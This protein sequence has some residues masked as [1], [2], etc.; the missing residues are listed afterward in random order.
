MTVAPVLLIEDTPSLQMVYRSVLRADGHSV[1]CEGTAAGGLRAFRQLRPRV[2]LLDLMLPDRDGLDLIQDFLC[3]ESET[4]VIVI[5][6]D[7][8]INKAV[9]AMRAGAYEFLV[10]PFDDQRLLGAVRSALDATRP[11][12]TGSTTPSTGGLIGSSPAMQAVYDIVGSVARSMATVFIT[13]ECGT[14][15]ELC[16]QAVHESSN[17]SAGPFVS[18]NCGAIAAEHL[19]SELFGHLKG[20]FAGALSDKQGAAAAADGGTLFLDEICEMDLAMQTKLLRFLQT[21]SIQPVGA[22]RSRKVDV[23]IVCATNNDPL[24]AV[25]RGRFRQDLYYRLHVVPIHMPSLRERGADVVEIA[26]TM[27]R[28][29]AAEEGRRFTGLSADV[30]ALF[31]RLPWPGN[32]RQMLNV[33]HHVVVLNDG[34]QVTAEMLPID[35]HHAGD[36]PMVGAEPEATPVAGLDSLIG[37]TLAE[38]ERQVI[39]ETI[40]RHGGSVPRA[41]RILDVSPST[42]YRKREAWLRSDKTA[43]E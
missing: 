22:T 40:A 41:A 1:H 7:G 16:A 20:A 8:S 4:S 38:I 35:L 6:A 21:S 36:A 2:V 14:G 42:L 31:Q 25:R 26:E 5:T 37:K 43:A 15:K 24:E 11:T 29:Y 17:R 28:R 13:G 10:K 33:L 3:R 30:A 39:E 27:L 12:E 23:R 19:G 32:V 9:Q 18:L 34:P